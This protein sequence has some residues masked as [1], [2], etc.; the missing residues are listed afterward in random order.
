MDCKYI[1]NNKVFLI[2]NA[3]TMPEGASISDDGYLLILMDSIQIMGI[4][5]SLRTLISK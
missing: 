1:K 4:L 5:E 3:V 2:I